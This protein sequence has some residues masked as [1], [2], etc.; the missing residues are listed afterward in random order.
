VRSIVEQGWGLQRNLRFAFAMR[1][2]APVALLTGILSGCAAPTHYMGIDISNPA[3]AYPLSPEQAAFFQEQN[4]LFA[5]AQA[6]GCIPTGPDDNRVA[7]LG[8]DQSAACQAITEQFATLEASLPDLVLKRGYADMPIAQLANAAQ[9]GNKT[10]QLELGIRFE[11]GR[12]VT[13]DL[14]KA[15]RLYEKAASD[16]LKYV[17]VYQTDADGGRISKLA[18]GTLGNGLPAAKLRLERLNRGN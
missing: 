11:E 3:P 9:S 13:K 10:A 7:E 16:D 4:L 2:L 15:K 8:G 14:D 18:A 17:D 6:A 12:G 5:K 1:A